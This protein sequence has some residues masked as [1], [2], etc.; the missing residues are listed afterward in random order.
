MS[1]IP[2]PA[3][4]SAAEDPAI[5]ARIRGWNRFYKVAVIWA[6]GWVGLILEKIVKLD[7]LEAGLREGG[8]GGA[9]A[10]PFMLIITL[11]LGL[12]GSRIGSWEKWR[13]YRLW[14]TFGLP[15]LYILMGVAGALHGRYFPQAR[16]Q[17]ITGVEFPREAKVER[18]VDDDGLGPFYDWTHI[19]E[20]S[21]PAGETERL[22]REMKLKE[23][24]PSGRLAGM[25]ITPP[26][27]WVTNEF[28]G[29][30]DGIYIELQT[31]AS[32]TKLRIV[33]WTT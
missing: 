4:I 21:C 12:L 20:L 11:P 31:D 10:S 19:Y 6:A 33:C 25:S 24:S 1:E 14:F 27:G 7:S 8:I 18:C 28:S 22:I 32:R 9:F 16:F 30:I 2:G 17:R 26:S 13:R 5:P 15:A 3:D 23:R 29:T